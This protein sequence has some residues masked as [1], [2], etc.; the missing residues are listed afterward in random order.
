MPMGGPFSTP[1]DSKVAAWDENALAA[2][3]AA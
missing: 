2:Y 1:I 3:I